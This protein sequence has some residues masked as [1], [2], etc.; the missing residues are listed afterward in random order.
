MR[1]QKAQLPQLAEHDR[2]DAAIDQVTARMVQ[3]RDDEDLALRIAGALPER[4]SRFGWLVPQCAAIVAFAIAAVVW[5]MRDI[6]TP[7]L[8]PLPSSDVVAVMAVPHTAPAVKPGTALRTLPLEPLE[9]LEPMELLEPD[10]ERSLSPIEGMKALSVAD[11]AT[12][13]IDP[14]APIGIASMEI[15]DLKMTA[16]TFTQKEE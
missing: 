6:A 7:S 8:L 15:A 9:P 2:V 16:E 14:L 4:S 5:T 1:P 13:P 11:A 3:V 10:F 12:H